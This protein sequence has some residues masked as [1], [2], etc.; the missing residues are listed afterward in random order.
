MN[1][2]V[3]AALA[4]G[5]LFVAFTVSVEIGFRVGSRKTPKDQ[6]GI[7]VIEGAVFGLLALLLAF[8]FGTGIAHLDARR[9]LVVAEAN[10]IQVAYRRV[11]LLDSRDQPGMRRLFER[12]VD[13]RVAAYRNTGNFEIR[14]Q[15][16]VPAESIANQIWRAAA[17]VWHGPSRPQLT[18]MV[19]PALDD[20][21]DIANQREVALSLHDPGLVLA[22]LIGVGLMSCV[23]AG[24]A[25]SSGGGR[26]LLHI[27]IYSLTLA[28]T[29]YTVIDL[30]YPRFGLIRIDAADRVLV[31]VQQMIHAQVH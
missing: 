7:R 30:D 11:D 16:F 26:S 17:R 4:T 14:E 15:A 2:I 20:M 23:I 21:F 24:Y 22:L 28:L 6:P 18:Q 25:L 27:A 31:Q 9:Q 13:A 3:V 1:A 5:A 10:A 29:I 12:Y 19:V 8:T